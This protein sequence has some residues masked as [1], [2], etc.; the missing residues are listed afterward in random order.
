MRIGIVRKKAA[1][2]IHAPDVNAIQRQRAAAMSA[3]VNSE[4]SMESIPDS[5]VVCTASPSPVISTIAAS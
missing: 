1:S 3:N 2:Q 5:R 4:T